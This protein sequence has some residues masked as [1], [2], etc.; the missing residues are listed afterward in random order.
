MYDLLFLALGC[1]SALTHKSYFVVI[2]D[3]LV[4]AKAY[5]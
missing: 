1:Y 4:H 3:V 5:L 2:V